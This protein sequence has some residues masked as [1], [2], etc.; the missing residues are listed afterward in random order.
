LKA[1]VR[2][3]RESNTE[4]IRSIDVEEEDSQLDLKS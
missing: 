4:S 3:L 1:I 2:F